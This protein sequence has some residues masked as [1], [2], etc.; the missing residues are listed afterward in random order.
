M[1]DYVGTF[2]EVRKRFETFYSLGIIWAVDRLSA[3]DCSMFTDIAINY[4]HMIKKLVFL[5]RLEMDCE[6]YSASV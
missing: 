3:Q 6:V 4:M 1:L 2:T 5:A